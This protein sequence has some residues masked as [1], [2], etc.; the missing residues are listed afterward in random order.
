MEFLKKW[1]GQVIG[2]FNELVAPKLW[3]LRKAVI[4]V[5]HMLLLRPLALPQP[6]P[7][8]LSL[9][10]STCNTPVGQNDANDQNVLVDDSR[11]RVTGIIDFGDCLH[12]CVIFELVPPVSTPASPVSCLP[13]LHTCL[14]A[15]VCD[16][17][18]ESVTCQSPL[19]ASQL[20]TL[21]SSRV[22][23]KGMRHAV[24]VTSDWLYAGPASMMRFNDALQ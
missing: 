19:L 7:L 21:L 15:H 17:A 1:C 8:S 22:A 24:G 10:R 3:S 16:L 9:S 20:P 11:Q 13:C 18:H 2:R 5:R 23:L 4:Q 12:T 14:T 6:C